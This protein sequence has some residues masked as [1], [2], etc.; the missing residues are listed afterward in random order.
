MQTQPS[1]RASSSVALM[2]VL[3]WPS[4]SGFTGADAWGQQ[5]L[6]PSERDGLDTLF[7]QALL[8]QGIRDRLLVQRDPTLLDA[9]GLSEDT[10]RWLASVQASTLTEFA[11]A[12]VDGS[13]PRHERA[14]SGA[15]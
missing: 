5:T 12:I 9:L 13:R 3:P 1:Y 4:G 14:A 2:D 10:R 7:G 6:S 11:Q 8:D 15:F